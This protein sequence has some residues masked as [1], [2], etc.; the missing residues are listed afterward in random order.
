MFDYLDI[1]DNTTLLSKAPSIFAEKAYEGMTERYAFIPTIAVINAMR[2]NGF[3]PVMATQSKCRIE[4]KG[5]YTK[6]MLRFR[7]NDF[8]GQNVSD[9]VPEI[10]LINSHDGTSAYRLFAGIFRMVCSNGMIICS[11]EMG[12]VSVRH[13]GKNDTIQKVIDASYEIINE[14]PKNF[15]KISEFKTVEL[16]PTEQIIL[17]ESALE[18]KGANTV[19]TIKPGIALQAQRSEDFTNN[20]GSRDLWKTFNVIQE[21]FIKGGMSGKTIDTNRKVKTRSIKA[22]SENL[23]INRGLWQLTEEMARLK[24]A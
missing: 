13:S 4:G 5:A 8:L 10:V 1:L 3:M 9:E 20:D 15:A 16:T 6:H 21:N 12:D 2:D 22:V 7:H 23:R 11:Q 14:T 18:L 17:A 19:E 24:A